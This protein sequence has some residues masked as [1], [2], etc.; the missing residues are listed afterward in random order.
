M[1]RKRD[2]RMNAGMKELI[3]RLEQ[4][5]QLNVQEYT[6]LIRFRDDESIQYLSE[7]AAAVRQLRFGR[8]IEFCG[9]IDLTNYCRNDC[10]YCGLRRENRFVKR[11][12]MEE[13]NVL[14]CCET[15]YI[16]GIRSFLIQ[17]GEDL[18]Y[19]AEK[20]SHIIRSVKKKYPDCQVILALGEKSK[21]V[22]GKWLEAGVDG[23]ILRYQSS[24]EGYFKKLHP[25]N[26]SLLKEKQCLWELKE[27]G[28]RLG[29]GFMVGTP[30]QKI[31][32]LAEELV[33]I[34]SLSPWL[35]MVGPFIPAPNTPF[36]GE[37]SGNVEITYY[38]LSILRLMLPTSVLPVATTTA[39]LDRMGNIKGV[40]AG[41]DTV[42]PDLSPR[43]IREDY[44]HYRK[45]MLRGFD[46]R[47]GLILL[48]QQLQDAGYE[49]TGDN[50]R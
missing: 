10:Y 18:Y 23:Y 1:R 31:S 24:D 28:Y 6:E 25:A 2:E 11:Y 39:I 27:M 33:F 30:N 15:G 21:T 36:E 35:V 8:R 3:D 49:I 50:S 16:Q 43:E 4:Q 14:S 40:Q 46:G 17:G 37:R 42:L 48:R 22:Y 7:R 19:T 9:L 38:L 32:H 12:R 20:F 34:K 26:M 45:R 5:R 44:H 41:A 29:T 47:E 13:E